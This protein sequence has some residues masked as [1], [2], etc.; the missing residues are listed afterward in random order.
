MK[1]VAQGMSFLNRIA[2]D[3]HPTPAETSET[4]CPEKRST[5]VNRVSRA[6]THAYR[7]S[8][9]PMRLT[10]PERMM[11]F[12]RR[13][14]ELYERSSKMD[15]RT[16]NVSKMGAGSGAEHLQQ[17]AN[18]R[19]SRGLATITSEAAMTET[20][21]ASCK[22]NSGAN[23][24]NGG[25]AIA[26]STM[27]NYRQSQA[28]NN[29]H[30]NN[31]HHTSNTNSNT[32][33]NGLTKIS[34]DELPN[35]FDKRGN[36]YELKFDQLS[37]ISK[38][39]KKEQIAAFWN[40]FMLF[41]HYETCTINATELAKT[42]GHIGIPVKIEDI[43]SIIDCY[44]DN[45]NGELDFEEYLNLMTNPDVFARLMTN[46]VTASGAGTAAGHHSAQGVRAS[47]HRPS[48][49]THGGSHDES[50]KSEKKDERS[51]GC[52]AQKNVAV[53]QRPHTFHTPNKPDY[54][55]CI[56]YEVMNEFF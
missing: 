24:V 19:E 17:S 39:L 37:E 48:S 51:S 35:L 52:K 15:K 45:Q 1:K 18:K 16:R 49:K 46:K 5:F 9:K 27:P 47:H 43:Q 38:H 34:N 54:R 41:D 8:T 26:K 22:M 42:L 33:A 25:G 20:A 4:N 21:R 53:I 40:A 36:F 13:M 12:E 11:H 2:H 55:D 32:H 7:P 56:M 30:H 14:P 50:R 10:R 29:P 28:N 6:T 3:D 44:D 23:N 31:T